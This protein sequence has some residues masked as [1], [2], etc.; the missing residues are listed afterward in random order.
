IRDCLC[1]PLPEYPKRDHVFSLAT[2]TGDQYYFQPINQTET[3]NW[4][5][6]IHRTCGQH[7]RTRRQSIVKE[8]R[9]NIRKLE[10]SIER[11]NTMRK[12]GELQLQASTTVKVRQLISKQ[13][14]LWEKNLEELHV[15]LFRQK[16]YLAALNDK[17]LPNPKVKY[18]FY[19]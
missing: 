2:S 12:L 1:Y 10:K 6:F 19:Y 9:R 14:E 7:N 16:C 4:I 5:K 15:D 3:D 17:N 8:L 13:I 11:E 18:L